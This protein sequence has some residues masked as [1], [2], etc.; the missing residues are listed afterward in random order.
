MARIGDQT[1]DTIGS[2]RLHTLRKIVRWLTR[3][4][5]VM[6]ILGI[7][8]GLQ[9]APVALDVGTDPV[10]GTVAV[11]PLAGGING[12]NSASVAARLKQART[13]PDIDAVVLRINSGG[14]GAAA[15]EE[16]YLEV[17]KTAQQ[18][19]VV[20]SVGSFSGSGAYYASL[21]SD[22]M[23]V[24][25]ATLVGNVGV[26]FTLPQ[27]LD[28]IEGIV[29]TGPNKLTGADQR[30]WYYKTD[31]IKRAF[32]NAVVEQRGEAL[33][34]SREEVAH[35][36]LYTG[37]EAVN[38]GFADEIGGIDAAISKAAELADLQRW[39]TRVL[40]YSDTVTFLT[41]TTYISAD[42]EDKVLI[43]PAAFVVPPE[44]AAAPNILMLPRSVVRAGLEDAAANGRSGTAVIPDPTRPMEVMTN[45]SAP[46]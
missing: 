1:R 3:S 27:E 38:N 7:I 42:V 5:I 40:G 39:N 4:Y 34:L 24:K 26:I 13:D 36:E 30:E 23:F 20:T 44:E 6:I 32:V 11:V 25:P 9:I 14:G 22:H 8:V 18:M 19:P 35:G 15:S 17:A 31:S 37:G 10:T 28:P 33:T 43:S 12:A 45:E 21:P 16:I 46:A 2:E 41:R 29:A